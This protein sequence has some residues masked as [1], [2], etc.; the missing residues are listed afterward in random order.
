MLETTASGHGPTGDEVVQQQ[1]VEG[2]LRT[3]RPLCSLVNAFSCWIGPMRIIVST[4]HVLDIVGGFEPLE[5][6]HPSIVD[7]LGEG[8]ESRRRRS[9]GSRHFD[10]EDGLMV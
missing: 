3:P 7:V 10:V 2:L 4:S 8:D 1:P 5:A 9:I 6:L